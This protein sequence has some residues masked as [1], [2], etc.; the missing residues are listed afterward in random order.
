[1][2]KK[3]EQELL[4]SNPTMGPTISWNGYIAATAAAK[5]TSDGP[6]FRRDPVE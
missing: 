4:A 6:H 1:M 3:T 5:T 2:S